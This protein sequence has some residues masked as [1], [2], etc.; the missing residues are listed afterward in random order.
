[1]K[2]FGS[3]KQVFSTLYVNEKYDTCLQEQAKVSFSM[4]VRY[5]LRNSQRTNL[6]IARKNDTRTKKT[7]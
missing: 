5:I 1:M 4:G 2:G 6:K 7:S 3:E